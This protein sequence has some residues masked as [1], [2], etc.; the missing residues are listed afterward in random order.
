MNKKYNQIN[1]PSIQ[2]KPKERLWTSRNRWER[3]K[4]V[5]ISDGDSGERRGCTVQVGEKM[6]LEGNI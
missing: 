6:G 5:V 2:K 4:E 3:H 1:I